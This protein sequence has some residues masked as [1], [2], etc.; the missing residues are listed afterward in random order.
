MKK[1]LN[2]FLLIFVFIVG[3]G[4]SVSNGQPLIQHVN[5]DQKVGSNEIWLTHEHILVDFVGADS[6]QPNSWKHEMPMRIC[7]HQPKMIMW[8][9]HLANKKQIINK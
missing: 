5:G 3:N 9:F 6:I 4:C 8:A 2:S 1:D 7:S